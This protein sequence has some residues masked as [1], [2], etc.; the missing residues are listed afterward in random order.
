M[1]DGSR[2]PGA[3]R[4]HGVQGVTA[5]PTTEGRRSP[6]WIG[7]T[8]AL[9][10]AVLFSA[11]AILAKL[12]YRTGVPPSMVIGLR[13]AFSLPVYVVLSWV[14]SRRAPTRPTRRQ[15]A[16]VATL[17][18]AGYYVATYLD[19]VG[20]T[21]ISAGLERVI[22][23]LHPA[24]V[25]LIASRLHARPI[26][27][28]EVLAMLL[29]YA[30]IALVFSSELHGVHG[31]HAMAGALVVLVS[32]IAYAAYLAFSES[33]AKSLGTT[34]FTGLT[35]TLACVVGVAQSVVSF[36]GDAHALPRD[37]IWLCAGIAAFATVIP[38]WLLNEAIQRLG[39]GRASLLGM[40][41]PVVTMVLEAV[42]L[43]EPASSLDLLGT[44]CA[45]AGVFALTMR[46]SAGG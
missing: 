9:L 19:F 8:F 24:I 10:S 18:L 17:S 4:A 27:R 20:L 12:A 22:L 43:G 14:G 28:R 40:S 30:G 11:K 16:Q 34:R 3:P 41:G 39:A 45:M 46:P 5:M 44:A 2:D 31:A 35:M 36:S 32:S 21:L 1:A 6:E 33:V 29:G 42:V 38:T 23:F 7:I 15:L 26:A 37:A 25:V 13:M